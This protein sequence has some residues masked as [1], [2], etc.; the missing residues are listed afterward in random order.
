MNE[1][2]IQR[3]AAAMNRKIDS[4]PSNLRPFT[5]EYGVLP[6]TAILTGLRGTGKTTFLLHH[7]VKSEKRILYL[8]ADNPIVSAE[9]LY[10]CVSYIF[11]KGYDG[12][13]V[14]E[15]HFAKDWSLHLKALSDDF[16]DRSIWASDSS[17][18]ILRQG[19]A[20]LSRRFVR[21]N[22]PLMSFREFL[23]LEMGASYDKYKFAST[24][25]PVKP[26][27]DIL[28]LF[29]TYKE[30]GTRPFYKEG[31]Y[32]EKA[33]A[34]LDKTMSSDVPFFVPQITA[35]NI[36]L[37]S[38]VVGTLAYSAIP[39]I[40]VRS[41]CSDW[42]LSADKL[43]QLLNV[44]EAV[45]I[46]RIIRYENDNKAKSSGAKIFLSDPCLYSVLNGNEGSR[47]EAFATMILSEAGYKVDASKNE[48]FGDFIIGRAYTN[49]RFPIE[50]GGKNKTIKQ[51]DYVIR[52]GTDYPVDKAIPLWLLAMLW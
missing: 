8:S 44:M 29:N 41:L 26:S 22:M 49:E 11:L 31:N 52:D 21:I 36:R 43:Y 28:Q 1:N 23:F 6:R 16:P 39:R 5:T 15:V 35:N 50:I 45:G 24:Q 32:S 40:Q 38:S 34:L 10:D 33:L 13:I 47:R 25:I 46:I 48:T 37:M 17:S 14:D 20:D 51:S 42:A 4:I 30:M 27:S 2:L 3:I 18:L 9:Q 19:N 12:V 7:A